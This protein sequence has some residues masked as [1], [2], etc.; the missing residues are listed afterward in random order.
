MVQRLARAGIGSPAVWQ[1]LGAVPR[2]AFVDSAL[3]WQAYEDTS[4]PIGFGQT[5][6]KPGTVA[7]M[8]QLLGEAPAARMGLM[9]VLE[10]GTGCGYQ[11]AVLAHMARAVYSIERLRGL[12][13]RA[14][15]NLH[16]LGLPHV[17]LIWGD[18]STGWA[19]GA[20]YSGIIAAAAGTDIPEVWCEQLAP[21][22]RLIAPVAIEGGKQAL[23]VVEKSTHGLTRS[24]VQGAY[25]VP[26]KPGME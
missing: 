22:A 12:H 5:V 11:A 19:S 1:A 15:A 18:G 2:H 23:V 14:H 13:E 3:A 24:V 21:G 8:L 9:R 20:P 16:A 7:R 25:F 26:L 6:S 4:L 10:I 17:T